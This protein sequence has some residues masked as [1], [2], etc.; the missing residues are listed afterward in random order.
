MNGSNAPNVIE[1][2]LNRFLGPVRK[3]RTI[4]FARQDGQARTIEEKCDE[5]EIGP[6]GSID[7]TVSQEAFFHD[8]GHY[9]N[10]NLGGRCE[11]GALACANCLAF[12]ASCGSP[13]C[14]KHQVTDLEDSKIYC[15]VCEEEIVR[16]RRIR[17]AMGVVT[18]FFVEKKAER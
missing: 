2:L 11:C 12:C 4:L 15:F 16:S 1:L 10:G 6:N 9:A 18:S 17:K 5:T 14:R 8:C 7:T 3:V 13:I